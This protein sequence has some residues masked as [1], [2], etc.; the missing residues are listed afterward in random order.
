MSTTHLIRQLVPLLPL[1][2]SRFRT[3]CGLPVI[4]C[5]S[6]TPMINETTCAV[7]AR[8]LVEERSRT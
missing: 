3:Y 6:V 4:E 1:R 7:C 5:N 8:L 2:R